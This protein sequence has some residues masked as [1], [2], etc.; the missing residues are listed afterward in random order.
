MSFLN[1][2]TG[3]SWKG[4]LFHICLILLV[5]YGL[6]WYFFNGYLPKETRH[7]EGINLPLIENMSYKKAKE[8][9][10]SKGLVLVI[11]DTV[12]SPKHKKSAIVSQLPEATKEV[13]LGRKV[14]VD[15]NRSDVP[16][17]EITKHLINEGGGLVLTDVGT[18][19]ITASN[20][21]L[22]TEI[23]YVNRPNANF[24]YEA[25]INNKPLEVGIKIPI[26]SKIVLIVG[27]GKN[28]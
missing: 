18:A 13:K 5:G 7:A 27:N 16:T 3:N 20:L 19:Q 2:V 26:G 10:E 4:V 14:Y 24:V 6:I 12:Y 23:I 8:L 28:R 22:V 11:R 21:E 17:V 9:L 25:K 15:L 1:I